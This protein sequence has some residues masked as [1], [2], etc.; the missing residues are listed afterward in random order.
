MRISCG[1]ETKTEQLGYDFELH[2]YSI[3][4]SKW[5]IKDEWNQW[6]VKSRVDGFVDEIKN[7]LNGVNVQVWIQYET[8]IWL[9]PQLHH[10]L[11]GDVKL[12]VGMHIFQKFHNL[13]D[14]IT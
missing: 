7:V 1:A 8:N 6:C 12:Y 14:G 2:S 10:T 4:A 5:W 11:S 13:F 3:P 9:M